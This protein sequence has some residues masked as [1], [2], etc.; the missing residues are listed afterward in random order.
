MRMRCAP[1]LPPRPFLISRLGKRLGNV[2]VLCTYHATLP[3]EIL[4]RRE[5]GHYECD[6]FVAAGA[7]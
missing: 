1:P 6:G 4:T 5:D 3:G 2:L 7:I